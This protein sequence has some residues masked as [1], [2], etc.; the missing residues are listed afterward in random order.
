[1]L[2]LVALPPVQLALIRA[3]TSDL[4]PHELELGSVWASPWGGLDLR[5]LRLSGPGYSLTIADVE[6]DIAVFSSITHWR[7]EVADAAL[8]GVDFQADLS[9]ARGVRSR[10]RGETGQSDVQLVRLWDVAKLPP[11]LALRS[12][13]A[14][15]TAMLVT[16]AG[17]IVSSDWRIAATGW[18]P[19]STASAELVSSTDIV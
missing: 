1:M 2:V 16:E 19:A 17:A 7:A 12:A 14:E 4:A 10:E 5:D 3:F 18:L 8:R 9:A 6:I 11:W 13:D 15:G